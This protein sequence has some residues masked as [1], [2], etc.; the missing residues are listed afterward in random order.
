MGAVVGVACLAT[1]GRAAVRWTEAATRAGSAG[2][3]PSGGGPP[4]ATARPARGP[5]PVHRQRLRARPAAQRRRWWRTAKVVAP[6]RPTV[7]AATG[8]G[9]LIDVQAEDLSY[10]A[11]RRLVI[12]RGGVKVTRGTDSV[13]ADYAEVDT[14]QEQVYARGNIFIRY[15]GGTWQGQEATYNFKTGAGNFG[16]FHAY[17]APYHVT[18]EGSTRE[19]PRL[20][21]LE[22]VMFTTCEPERPEYSLRAKSASIEDNNIVRAKHVRFHFGPVPFF[23]VPYMRA[24]LEEL[25]KFEFTPGWSSA[26][27]PFLLTTYNQP[28]NDI[29]KTRTHVDIRQKRGLGVGEDLVWKDP[30]AGD[31]Q[32]EAGVYYANDRKPWKDAEE[33]TIREELI[34][35]DRCWLKL[36]DRHNLT[37]RDYLITKLNYVSD[38][39]LLSDFFDDEYQKNVQ[40]ENRVTLTHRGDHYSA[41]VGLNTRLND[42]Y[43]NVN[44]LPEVFLNFNRQK[45]LDTPFYEGEIRSAIWIG[46]FRR[47]AGR[48]YDAFRLIP[49]TWCIGRRVTSGS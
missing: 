6:R 22:Q 38:P 44:R 18:A 30:V 47:G 3:P 49:P 10:D 17:S 23:W 14:A 26:M 11:E 28:I 15:M 40:P 21:K 31:Y 1:A 25:A 48:H 27:G 42:F 35:N 24:N 20:M 2:P 29:F 9:N 7:T 12:A 5:L 8:G 13:A 37:D 45:I 46:C 36:S 16:A 41:G 39:W 4:P 43:G 34:D 19:S 33:R 32:G